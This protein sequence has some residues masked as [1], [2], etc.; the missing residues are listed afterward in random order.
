MR[1]MRVLAALFFGL[2]LITATSLAMAG[3]TV[4]VG[5]LKFGTVNWEIDTIR[6]YELDRKNGI[7]LDV[8]P[9]A[10]NEA[11]RIA[12]LSGA[13]D[14]IVSDWLF[15]SRQRAEG[16]ALAFVPY[17][18]SVGAIMVPPGSDIATLA[19]LK[20]KTIGV[21]GGPLDKSW[22]M[23]RGLAEGKAGFDLAAE[24]TQAFAAPPLLAEKLRQGELDAAVNYWHYNARLE[25]EGYRLLVSAQAAAVALGAN[26]DIS[27]IGYVFNETWANDNARTVFGFVQASRDAKALLA[28]SDEAWGRLKPMMKAN[29]EAVFETLVKR[30][31]QGIPSRPIAEE[32]ADTARIYDYLAKVGGEKLVGK[33]KAM[34]P[35]TFWSVLTN[36]N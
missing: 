14:I 13:V 7:E 10:G 8:V 1:R 30:Y 12:L 26:G 31:R 16:M 4:R 15:V 5:V 9:L 35:G 2:G 29:D 34:A 19:D 23:L 27:A 18:T 33:A 36:G 3:E 6:H 20:G 11:T 24:T 22:L 32:E 25:A 17:S 21:A 28:A